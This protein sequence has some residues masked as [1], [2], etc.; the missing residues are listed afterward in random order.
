[1]A[2][3]DAPID[4]KLTELQSIKLKTGRKIV[5]LSSW[6]LEFFKEI[7]SAG[8][9]VSILKQK[10]TL[11]RALPKEYDVTVE[12]AMNANCDYH[13][14]VA[15][16]IV[17]ESRIIKQDNASNTALISLKWG[18]RQGVNVSIVVN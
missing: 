10:R 16:L 8:H 15:K 1:M 13:Q 12:F 9:S 3:S 11:L 17:R 5:E 4:S 14:A 2:L 7:D 18:M 6:I